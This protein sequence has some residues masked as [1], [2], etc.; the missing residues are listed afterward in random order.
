MSVTLTIMRKGRNNNVETK[1]RDNVKKINFEDFEGYS[2]EDVSNLPSFPSFDTSNVEYSIGEDASLSRFDAKHVILNN[3]I[4]D[5]KNDYLMFPSSD[6]SLDSRSLRSSNSVQFVENV[7]GCQS[8]LLNSGRMDNNNSEI[9][10]RISLKEEMNCLYDSVSRTSSCTVNGSIQIKSA[11]G[12]EGNSFYL[13]IKDPKL[14]LESVK[15]NE[16][17]LEWVTDNKHV[18]EGGKS[19]HSF[20]VDI[21]RGVHLTNLSVCKYICKSTTLFLPMVSTTDS[22]GL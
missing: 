1:N 17:A 14:H 20:L 22:E 16:E 13:L 12:L 8:D 2:R 6:L 4:C 19:P 15:I 5:E 11:Q 21:S 9:K 3:H 10:A 18:D 7:I